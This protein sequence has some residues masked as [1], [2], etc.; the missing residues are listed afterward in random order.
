MGR[1]R[2]QDDDKPQGEWGG[3]DMERQAPTRQPEEEDD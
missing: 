3:T 1:D 2:D